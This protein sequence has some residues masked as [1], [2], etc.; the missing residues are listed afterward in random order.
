M[1]FSVD[2]IQKHSGTSVYKNW[3]YRRNMSQ[4][5]WH[6]NHSLHLSC[7]FKQTLVFTPKPPRLKR[8]VANIELVAVFTRGWLSRKTLVTWSCPFSRHRMTWSHCCWYGHSS[9]AAKLGHDWPL[10]LQVTS[11]VPLEER[12]QEASFIQGSAAPELHGCDELGAHVGLPHGSQKCNAK[13]AT[14]GFFSVR[15]KVKNCLEYNLWRE[16]LQNVVPFSCWQSMLNWSI[17]HFWLFPEAFLVT[18]G[19]T[20]EPTLSFCVLKI[21]KIF[22]LFSSRAP[23]SPCYAECLKHLQVFFSLNVKKLQSLLRQF[24]E[25]GFLKR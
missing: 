15:L 6:L 10:L 14:L 22:T 9:Q 2:D 20:R 5:K 25:C 11:P 23:G 4:T 3:H 1:W 17:S 16:V 13:A 18:L 21:K 19:S 8:K 7:F 24:Y 12:Q